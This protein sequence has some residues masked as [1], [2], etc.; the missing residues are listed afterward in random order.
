MLQKPSFEQS[1]GAMESHL[2]KWQ[3]LKN[4]LNYRLIN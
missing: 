3:S 2:G 4:A 1:D